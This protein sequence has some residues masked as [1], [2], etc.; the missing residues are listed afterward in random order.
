MERKK[1]ASYTEAQKR[2]IL[3]Y[4]KETFKSIN[5]K[6]RHEEIEY[7]RSIAEKKGQSATAYCYEAV[8]KQIAEDE[9]KGKEQ[10]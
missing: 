10:A 4:Q 8:R 3:K 9:A 5:L 2:A 7:L 1:M 6:F